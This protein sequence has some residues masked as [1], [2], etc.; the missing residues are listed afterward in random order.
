MGLIRRLSASDAGFDV[1]LAALL[2]VSEADRETV[3]SAVRDIIDSVREGGDT[4]V[5]E[6]TNQFDH[7]EVASMD[8][9]EIGDSEM[10]AAVS[11]ID[12]LVLG[13]LESSIARVRRYHEQ[14]KRALGDQ[15]DWGYQD[16]DGNELGQ[17][18]RG[19][20]RV[21][22]YAPGGKAS[23]P[24]TVIMTAVP[25][26]VAEV[27]EI[28]LVVPAPHGQVS[29]VLL[30]AASLCGVDR[31][32]TIGGAQAV[33]ALAHGTET[34]PKV[35]KIVGPGNIFVATAKEL[36][37]GRVGIDMIAGPSEIVIVADSS[38]NPD[39]LVMDMFAQAEH[40]EM[41]QAIVIST[42]AAL[43]DDLASR[44]GTTLSGME[45]K[46]IIET[47]L[48]DRGALI[49]VEDLAQAASVANRIAPE[50]L[51]LA[52]ADPD[53]MLP[54]V[55]HAGAI[56]IGSHTAE[57]MGDYCAGPSHVLPTSGTA[58]FTSPLGV[59]DFQVR[60]SVIRCSPKGAVMLGRDAS[61][62]ARE[63]GLEA[64][65]RSADYRSEG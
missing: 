12:P 19:M 28:I 37:F 40:D 36:V 9:L 62:L 6:L 3:R 20:D 55:R 13:A 16:D 25:A 23:Y 41:A 15:I 65:A 45:R 26:R 29:D 27:G 35:D 42:D 31:L 30:A 24:S 18:V 61:I 38:V 34:V 2:H 1:Q 11:R 22:I 48:A 59:Y 4:R 32:F 39:W 33:A 58:R 8:E 21:G 17:R 53:R 60:S 52:V 47:S 5:V 50:H 46:Q 63:E 64:H 56:F 44:I 51:E 43:L 57:V 7:R 14:Q 49:L 10:A 54:L